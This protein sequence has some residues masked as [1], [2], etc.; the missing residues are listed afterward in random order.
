MYPLF[1]LRELREE[2]NKEL[3]ERYI[4]LTGI[5][6]AETHPEPEEEKLISSV[7]RKDS[8]H[9]ELRALKAKSRR[10]EFFRTMLKKLF[11]REVD[12]FDRAFADASTYI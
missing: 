8:P 10:G 9:I 12:F 11:D 1:L 5:D 3:Y 7:E 4:Q 2:G 6:I